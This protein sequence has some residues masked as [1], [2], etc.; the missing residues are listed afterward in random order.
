MGP[1]RQVR[2]G[3]G[4]RGLHGGAAHRR[5]GTCH[6]CSRPGCASRRAREARPRW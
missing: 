3:A 2:G 4:P 6:C 1:A 5:A